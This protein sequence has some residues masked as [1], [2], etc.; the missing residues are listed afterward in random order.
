MQT[1]VGCARALSWVGGLASLLAA[2]PAAA[3]IEWVPIGDLGNPSDSTPIG[4]FG[5]VDYEYSISKFETT[6]AEYADF[7]NAKAASDPLG[8]YSPSME[9]DTH[10]G[11]LRMGSSG[12]YTYAAKAGFEEE[13]VNFVTFFD[14][15][16]F[17]N[18]LHNGEG[19]G[20][21]E[22]GAY[23]LL[24]GSETPSN[25]STVER[26][27]DASVVVPTQ[28]E[29]FK[30][31]YY[32]PTLGIY[33][34][35]PTGTDEEPDCSSPTATP[36]SANCGN[37]AIRGVTDVGSYTGSPS[38][39][40]T[41]DQGGNVAE[42]NEDITNVLS[43]RRAMRGGGWT[44]LATGLRSSGAGSLLPDSVNNARG[45]RLVLLPE[46]SAGLLGLA[47]LSTLALLGVRRAPARYPRRSISITRTHAKESFVRIPK[48]LAFLLLFGGLSCLVAAC[49]GGDRESAPGAE[50]AAAKPSATA[51]AQ[52]MSREAQQCLDLVEQKRFAE[53]ID[54]CERALE[55]A[56]QV[57]SADV[58]QAYQEAKDAVK[59]EAQR[60]AADA[61]K[62]AGGDALRNLGG[63][64]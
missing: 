24:G 23:T 15:L 53:A 46:P 32:D 57:A 30:A 38:P 22:T 5:S 48:P 36:N 14:A 34:D 44:G 39:Y 26:N 29:W 18:W 43:G 50:G 27:P 16:R 7:L 52:Q 45:F 41:F 3:V 4:S 49:G 11:I 12:S 64:D 8:L 61:A 55:S 33:Y 25:G 1:R 59:Q 9:S 2:A 63:Q 6:N 42:W 40:G 58:Q 31:A 37:S 13:P 54:P 21:T 60:A 10:G 62:D 28:D 35:Y 20:D 17:A 19:S 47:A 56:G 51:A